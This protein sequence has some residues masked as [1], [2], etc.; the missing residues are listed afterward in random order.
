MR[1]RP[2]I[3][4]DLALP[5]QGAEALGLGTQEG[6]ELT[7]SLKVKRYAV[8]DKHKALI[9]AIYSDRPPQNVVII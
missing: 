6:G 7:S 4:G 1:S 5:D 2:S 8:I 3:R 9:A